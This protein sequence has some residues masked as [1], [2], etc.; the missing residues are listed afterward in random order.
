MDVISLSGRRVSVH[1]SG[2]P[3]KSSL[4]GIRVLIR[5]TDGSSS[6]WA[7][8][9]AT[10]RLGVDLVDGPTILVVPIDGRVYTFVLLDDCGT[11]DPLGRLPRSATCV[12]IKNSFAEIEIPKPIL[13]SPE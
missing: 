10:G 11:N 13:T 9:G 3:D 1:V 7:K 4:V 8:T 5:G 12:S 6:R 2:L